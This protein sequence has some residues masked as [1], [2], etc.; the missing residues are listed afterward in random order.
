VLRRLVF[1]G[2]FLTGF[3][4]FALRTVGAGALNDPPDPGDGHDY[5]AIAF[6][7]WQGRGF[8]YYWSDPT[9]REPYLQSRRYRPVLRRQSNYYPTTYRP[10]AMPFVLS[11]VYA[12]TNRNFAAWRLVN[13]V[14]AAGAVTVAAVIAAQFAGVPAA[15]VTAALALNAPRLTHYSQRFLTEVLAAFLIT[16]LAWVWMR[17]IRDR[18]SL[19]GTL[20]FGTL[21]GL[22]IATRSIFVLSLPLVILVAGSRAGDLKTA[23]RTKVICL[24]MVL[25]VIGP[26]WMRNIA[27]TGTFMPLGTQGGIN[28]PMGFGPRALK[29]EGIWRSNNEDGWP[30]IRQQD[31]GPVQSEVALA[32]WRTAETL[33]WMRQHPLEVLRLMWLHV[34]QEIRPRG[35]GMSD[36]FFPAAVIGMIVL[37]TTPGI[38]AVIVLVVATLAGIAMTYSNLG[39]FIVPLEP[40]FTAVIGAAVVTLARQAVPRRPDWFARNQR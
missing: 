8:G 10:P 26:W 11:A 24:A 14:F 4:V 23:L 22:L 16:L 27:V 13:C 34:A 7:L 29:F 38:S 39:R 35:N 2:I 25:A 12:A 9:W 28:L 1:L 37:R 40:L 6:N 3:G 21:L 33:V 19:R 5:D 15:L 36:W 20:L 17:N 31:L 18:W 30:E 32:K